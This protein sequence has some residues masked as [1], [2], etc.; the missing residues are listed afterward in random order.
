MMK[1]TVPRTT[2]LS[3]GCGCLSL[4]FFR[5]C[6]RIG[7]EE[8]SSRCWPVNYSDSMTTTQS[9]LLQMSLTL[10][11]HVTFVSTISDLFVFNLKRKRISQCIFITRGQNY[12]TK[13]SRRCGR[14]KNLYMKI[15][16]KEYIELV[17]II[18]IWINMFLLCHYTKCGTCT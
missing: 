12:L 4:Y 1:S 7:V 6:F 9:G 16:V 14:L 10:R 3:V 17:N 11:R 2:E 8:C 18:V 13:W 15:K 5:P